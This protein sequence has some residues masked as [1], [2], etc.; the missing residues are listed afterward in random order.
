MNGG[1]GISSPYVAHYVL[2]L[3]KNT[4]ISFSISENS[5]YVINHKEV[6]NKTVQFY[7]RCVTHLHTCSSYENQNKLRFN[8]SVRWLLDK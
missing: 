6:N 2:E 5:L 1:K 3:L 4:M 7:H 8:A